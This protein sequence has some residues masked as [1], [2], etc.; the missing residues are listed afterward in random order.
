V[1]ALTGITHI[2]TDV[3][4]Y[5]AQIGQVF[6]VLDNHDSE[7]TSYGVLYEGRRRFVKHSD[8]PQGIASLRRAIDVNRR[9][10][11][12]ALPRLYHSF[13]TPHGL[14]LVYAWAPGKP[15]AFGS[16]T[17]PEKRSDPNFAPVRFRALPLEQILAS[18]DTIFDVHL[19]VA[20]AGLIAVDFYDGGLLYDFEARRTTVYDLDE[21]RPGPFVLDADRNF[22][23]SRFMAP[24]EFQRGA[25]I[26]QATNVFTLGRTAIL[27]LGDGLPRSSLRAQANLWATSDDWRGTEAMKAVLLRATDPE[28]AARYQTVR[29][30][31]GAWRAAAGVHVEPHGEVE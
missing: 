15:L 22:G 28:R 30:F 10:Q 7:C 18:I 21:Y 12:P 13:T 11:H 24:E 19:R 5:L 29:A 26:D 3:A 9:V 14:A 25:T 20:E 2:E 17:P 23:S 16:R 27:L 8:R 4:A 6:C 1:S 31:V